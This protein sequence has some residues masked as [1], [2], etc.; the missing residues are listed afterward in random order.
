M[1]PL[2]A[3]AL[4]KA[5][6]R[7]LLSDALRRSRHH[8]PECGADL[9][10]RYRDLMGIAT[11]SR[12][13][14]LRALL[15]FS[16]QGASRRVLDRTSSK[17]FEEARQ[18]VATEAKQRETELNQRLE[19]AGLAPMAAS[20][21]EIEEGA[22]GAGVGTTGG[23]EDGGEEGE[24]GE[25]YYDGRMEEGE[26]EA[27]EAEGEEGGME[28]ED[29]EEEGEEEEEEGGREAEAVEQVRPGAAEEVAAGRHAPHSLRTRPVVRAPL[30]QLPPEAQR[31][32]RLPTKS[33]VAGY[34]VLPT[35]GRLPFRVI[36]EAANAAAVPGGGPHPSRPAERRGR[37]AAGGGAAAAPPPPL[38]QNVKRPR[39]ANVPWMVDSDYNLESDSTEGRAS[40]VG[41]RFP[42][43]LAAG[44][45]AD[46]DRAM[47]LPRRVNVV[48]DEQAVAAPARSSTPTIGLDE[49]AALWAAVPR[50]AYG[51]HVT[52]A[53][54]DRRDAADKPPYNTA[55]LHGIA[56]CWEAWGPTARPAVYY[57]E[58][59]APPTMGR[60]D[61]LDVLLGELGA[62]DGG[63]GG[64]DGSPRTPLNGDDAAASAPPLAGGHPSLPDGP[65]QPRAWAALREVMAD[66]RI[67]KVAHDSKRQ[68]ALLLARGVRL[69]G[70]LLDPAIAA[71]LLAPE[72]PGPGGKKEEDSVRAL[73]R[74]YAAPM[75]RRLQGAQ[76]T[77]RDL[78]CRTVLMAYT[79]M[80]ALETVMAERGIHDG[81]E[82][83]EMQLPPV[84]ARME[85]AGFRLSTRQLEIDRAEI[86][87][88]L[89][90]IEMDARDILGGRSFVW[91]SDK[92]VG[93]VLFDQLRLGE[94]APGLRV[95]KRATAARGKP[96]T[97]PRDRAWCTSTASLRL[98]ER[99]HPLPGMIIAHRHL[100]SMYA[101][102]TARI[103]KWRKTDWLTAAAAGG[104]AGGAAYCAV[105][106]T[107]ASTGR[108]YTED[109]NMQNTAKPFELITAARY[110]TRSLHEERGEAVFPLSLPEGCKVRAQ[111]LTGE[112]VAAELQE[113]RS[114]AIDQPYG[115]ARPEQSLAALWAEQGQ[116]YT[117]AAAR[118]VLQATVRRRTAEGLAVEVLPSD[119]VWRMRHSSCDARWPELRPPPGSAVHDGGEARCV[120]LRSVFVARPGCVL[121][122]ADYSQIELRVLAH[123]SADEGLLS[124]FNGGAPHAGAGAGQPC[125]S[126]STAA[127]TWAQPSSAASAALSPG[128]SPGARRDIFRSIASRL[129]GVPFEEVSDELRSRA[130]S[131]AYAT[132]YG[133]GIAHLVNELKIREADARKLQRDWNATYAT[134]YRFAQEVKRDCRRHGYVTTLSGRKRFLPDIKSKDRAAQSRAER[135][136]VNSVVQGSAADLIKKAMVRLDA[137]LQPE[138]GAQLPT[139][140]QGRLLLQVCVYGWGRGR[141]ARRAPRPRHRARP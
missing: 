89:E 132:L 74:Q 7:G 10:G 123:L 96:G 38:P 93:R 120:C 31:P 75:E 77:V 40:C 43:G 56:V 113:L 14:V 137:E 84:L 50:F 25:Q 73:A 119:R 48:L 37:E 78:C 29:E 87:A 2:L 109:P 99:E 100:T 131:A 105:L 33:P 53:G 39:L 41:G 34:T 16:K 6:C 68:T 58:L 18:H 92:E 64:A 139:A 49:F 3:Q 1:T 79:V 128:A 13:A 115:L 55:R 91:G 27:E 65:R 130:K 114:V 90:A 135:Q 30:H 125:F 101:A 52:D 21:A 28:E 26:E 76:G 60:G 22:A 81:F 4:F 32:P 122:S 17:L 127:P 124:I 63:G 62:E 117:E 47:G 12:A 116:P 5:G 108:L 106:Q 46:D 82:Q 95:P 107:H 8:L 133:S 86:F 80:P 103:L 23:E 97:K 11:S 83:L 121:V 59:C 138:A 44:T 45:R 140:A 71:W 42:L 20:V 126:S 102:S 67:A 72:R 85:L 57:L 141:T 112:Y 98:I 69:G 35:P 54:T 51:L 104:E 118:G 94:G 19:T 111:L 61:A 36:R 9:S 129:F 110:T 136:A 24:A 66:P 15:Q 70:P 88:K 134:A